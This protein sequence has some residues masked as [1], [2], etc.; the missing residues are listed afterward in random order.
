[1]NDIAVIV[2]NWNACAD[3]KACL[4]SP[5]SDLPGAITFEV[6]VVDN[7]STDG[8]VEMVRKEFPQVNLIAN[9]ENVGFSKANNQA[10]RESNT[11]YVFLLNSDA[12]VHPGAIETLGN[13]ANVHPTSAIIG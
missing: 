3:L 4:T 5:Y 7:A 6:W 11:K 2:V 12:T 10:I 1:M 9:A 8:S 13:Y